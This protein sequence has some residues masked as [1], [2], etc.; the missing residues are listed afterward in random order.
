M[1]AQNYYD[2]LEVSKDADPE[3][4]KR[5]YR[6]LVLQAHPDKGGSVVDFQR[7]QDAYATLRDSQRRKL[8]DQ[9]RLTEPLTDLLCEV[10]FT[11]KQGFKGHTF[12][13]QA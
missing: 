2:L 6:K 13:V 4:I 10:P 12:M 8:Y 3:H 5:Q 7:L 1:Q 11:L 9:H